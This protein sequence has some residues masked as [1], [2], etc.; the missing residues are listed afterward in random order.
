MLDSFG[1]ENG[2][3]NLRERVEFLALNFNG[4]RGSGATIFVS[5][6]ILSKLS[7]R[8]QLLTL[9]I[10]MNGSVISKYAKT[11]FMQAAMATMDELLA[12]AQTDSLL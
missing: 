5:N 4:A 11:M 8:T 3:T 12:L 7:S 1:G 6:I 2:S 10:C 9:K